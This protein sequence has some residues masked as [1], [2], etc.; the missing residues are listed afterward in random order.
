MK[1]GGTFSAFTM[2]IISVILTGLIYN[3]AH[4]LWE[5]IPDVSAR[6]KV[7]DAEQKKDYKYLERIDKKT[8]R[9]IDI[10]IESKK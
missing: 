2:G 10:L 5:V 1:H 3:V 8:D 7:I 4:I 9:I 6:V